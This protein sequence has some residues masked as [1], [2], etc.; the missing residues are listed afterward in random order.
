[1]NTFDA[2]RALR[3]QPVHVDNS[4]R[5]RICVAEPGG[6]FTGLDDNK[7]ALASRPRNPSTGAYTGRV[8][9]PQAFAA[10]NPALQQQQRQLSTPTI[11]L[12]P[13]NNSFEV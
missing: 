2:R 11:G 12:H 8:D 6:H 13:T 5:A 10:G 4:R 7:R 3:P 9:S 1:V